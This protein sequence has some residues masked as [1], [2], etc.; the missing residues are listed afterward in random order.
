MGNNVYKIIAFAAGATQ[1]ATLR[2]LNVGC[3]T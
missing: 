1:K 2:T 3:N